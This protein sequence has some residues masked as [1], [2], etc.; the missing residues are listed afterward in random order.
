MKRK[1]VRGK[2]WSSTRCKRRWTSIKQPRRSCGGCK[3]SWCQPT[4]ML[5]PRAP[6]TPSPDA[7]T[8]S[9]CE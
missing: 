7:T 1:G 4:P 5:R 3:E 6:S 8:S 2:S 9:T